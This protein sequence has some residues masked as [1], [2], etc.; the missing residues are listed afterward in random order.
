MSRR[1]RGLERGVGLVVLGMGLGAG[2]MLW[3]GLTLSDPD[4]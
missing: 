3:F 4:L 1:R 2:V